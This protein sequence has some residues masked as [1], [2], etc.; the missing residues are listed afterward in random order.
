MSF[1]FSF[2][3]AVTP[4]FGKKIAYFCMEFAIDQRLKTYS[5]GLGF[6]AGSH[7]RSAF[8]LKQHIVGIGILWK[9][10]YY[11][12]VKAADGRMEV[13]FIARQYDFLQKTGISFN[14]NLGGQQTLVEV[15]Y[16]PPQVFQTAPVFFLSTDTDQNSML[17]R[18]A[19]YKLYDSDPEKKL[20]ASILLGEGGA[21]LLEVLD[22][23]PDI[24]H[25]N[26]SQALPLAFHL[27]NRYQDIPEVRKRL[28]FTNHTP[29][30]GG[31]E[32]TA[33]A[34]LSQ[35]DFFGNMP[36][37]VLKDCVSQDQTILE[38]TPA[39]LFFA[40]RANGV[41]RIHSA[42]FLKAQQHPKAI[43]PITSV[44]NAQSFSY[45]HDQ[46]LY[47]ALK[48]NDDEE[49]Y[50]RKISLKKQLFEEVS[51]QTGKTYKEE[52]LTLV[53]AKRF[54]GYK[55]PG[56]LLHDMD[57]FQRIIS[58]AEKPLQVI[59]AG[60]PHPTD[61]AGVALFNK[62]VAFCKNTPGCSV[63]FGYELALSK[64]LKQGADAWLN[65]P[66]MSHEASGTS[67]MSAAMNGTVNIA[68]ADGWFPEF[69]KDNINGFII[70]STCNPI[71]EEEEN[72]ADAA[73]LYDLLEQKIIPLYYD[74]PG[75][76]LKI[77]KNG[78]RD[79][80]PAFD[81]NRMVSEYYEKLYMPHS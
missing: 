39:A 52:V 64:L 15:Y 54:G 20:A 31:N 11:D 12:Q 53:F 68:M 80:I 56:L 57:R 41:S 42:G 30:P 44:T 37:T 32:K 46:Q 65:V 4:A 67:G 61:G 18:S 58:H 50:R 48:N 72:A 69:A 40:G 62:I 33:I 66:R 1:T 77:V 63:L 6:L 17:A 38:H 7:I 49:L 27:Y 19:C 14:I 51:A 10:G 60:K 3:Y 71:S 73:A 22:W 36:V 21:R 70:P 9:Y 43:C 47:A 13:Q 26:E 35:L 25:L 75:E 2:P 59:W 79:I 81:S 78:M 5:G 16:L 45:W 34:L 24:Y 74:A 28:V 29:E 76:W 8:E 23:Q 55:R